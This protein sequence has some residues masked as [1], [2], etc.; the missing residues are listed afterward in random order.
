MGIREAG[1]KARDNGQQ[2]WAGHSSHLPP[3]SQSLYL[4]DLGDSSGTQGD[5]AGVT[6]LGTQLV[7]YPCT[8]WREM[9]QRR[10]LAKNTP[11]I[12]RKINSLRKG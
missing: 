12:K 6:S 4:Q 9:R 8:R 7:I 3:P 2:L 10:Q 1:Q 5:G 11:Q